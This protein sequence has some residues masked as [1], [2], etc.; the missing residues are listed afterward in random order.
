MSLV[1]QSKAIAE[2]LDT[3][4]RYARSAA[5]VLITG[6]SGT[7]KELLGSFIHQ[8]S[9]RR[10]RLFVRVNCSA[11]SESLVESELFGHER[12]AFTGAVCSRIGRIE[13]ARGG[14]LML[15]EISEVPLRMQAKLLRVLEEEEFQRVGSNETIQADARIVA[16]SNRVLSRA[17]ARKRFRQDLYYRLNVLR[18]HVPALRE[19]RDDIPV[20]VH[21]FLTRFHKLEGLASRTVSPERCNISVSTIGLVTFA[22]SETLSIGCA[23]WARQRRF[24]P[25]I[26]LCWKSRPVR[27]PCCRP[28]FERCGW[29]RSSGTSFSRALNSSVATRL[30]PHGN[31]ASRRAPCGTR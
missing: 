19:R 5:T 20:L 9:R 15:D 30:P 29:T 17:V 16:T 6:E 14:T 28:R 13:A 21:H 12:G 23:S 18:L 24:A 10:E 11:L 22:N 3:A 1:F 8:Q 26:C 31:W 7:G 27:L 4:R 2:L 25:K